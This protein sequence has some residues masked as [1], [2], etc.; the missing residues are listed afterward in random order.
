VRARPALAVLAVQA[1]ARDL[2]DA[3][4][5]PEAALGRALADRVGDSAIVDLGGRASAPAD[6]ELHRMA[7]A[8]LRAADE[9]IERLDAVHE[10]AL[11]QEFER[12]VDGG[13][14]PGAAVALE[15][16]EDRIGADQLMAGPHQHQ[17]ALASAAGPRART[18]RRRRQAPR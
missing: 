1:E 8:G 13:R 5:D 14:G 11:Q 2:D 7:G 4:L 15:V 12:P 16:V 18:V 6:Q 10:A 3:A 9:R 17:H